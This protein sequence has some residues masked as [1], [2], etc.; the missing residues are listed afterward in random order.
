MNFKFAPVI[1]PGNHTQWESSEQPEGLMMLTSDIALTTDAS[2]Y[3]IVHEFANDID[4]LNAAFSASWYKM[5]TR[6]MGPVTRCTGPYVPPAQEFQNPLPAP[7]PVQPDWTAVRS[8]VTSVMY[9]NVSEV[10]KI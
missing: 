8:A 5:T 2:Y 4:A 10:S 9:S 3:A 6:D 7:S 1:S